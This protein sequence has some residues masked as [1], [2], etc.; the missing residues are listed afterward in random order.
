M[1]SLWAPWRLEYILSDKETGCF[2]CEAARAESDR[3][4]LVVCRRDGCFCVLNKYPYNNGHLLIA[5]NRHVAELA[6]LSDAEML[7]LM[8][9]ARDA[10]RALQREMS[11]DGFNLGAN[12]GKIAGAGV[13]GHFHLHIVP[14]WAG[15]TNFMPVVGQTKVIPQSLEALWTALTEQFA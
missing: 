4:A 3:D 9:L 2:L 1:N 8:V 12:L 15:D 10:Q 11:P 6:D 14:R 7:E 13:P 5:P